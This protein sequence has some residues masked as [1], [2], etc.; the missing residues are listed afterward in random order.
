[1]NEPEVG[2]SSPLAGS[3]ARFAATLVMALVAVAPAFGGVL[4]DRVSLPEALLRFVVACAAIWL[5]GSLTTYFVRRGARPSEMVPG[6][7]GADR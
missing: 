2:A 1:M 4:S 5:V 6:S 7:A 3:P